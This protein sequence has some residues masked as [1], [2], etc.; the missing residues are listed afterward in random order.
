MKKVM[1]AVLAVLG[2]TSAMPAYS[3]VYNENSD[4][5]DVPFDISKSADVPQYTA[6]W[7]IA[8][9]YQDS[10]VAANPADLVVSGERPIGSVVIDSAGCIGAVS[11]RYPGKLAIW[12]LTYTGDWRRARRLYTP[13]LFLPISANDERARAA[14]SREYQ[15]LINQCLVPSGHSGFFE[16]RNH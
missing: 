15:T 7:E 8:S 14:R 4:I 9:Q 1:M 16:A 2:F 6:E 3:L 10:W 11:T 13:F 5:Y 12:K